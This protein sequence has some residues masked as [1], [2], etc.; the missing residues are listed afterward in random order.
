MLQIRKATATDGAALHA[1]QRRAFAEDLIRYGDDPTCPANESKARLLYKMRNSDYYVFFYSG[2]LIGG[3]Q[4]A[5][6]GGGSYRL[7]RIYI[8][9]EYQN[10]G[11]GSALMALLEANYP[12]ARRFSLDTPHLNI[13]NHHFYEKLGYVKV[14][15]YKYNDALTLFDF[16]KT[17]K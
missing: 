4:V 11:L 7:N 12:L 3:A 13:R 6:L 1:I 2:T 5:D 17:I 10:K 14:G 16:V 15:E 8:D 9:P